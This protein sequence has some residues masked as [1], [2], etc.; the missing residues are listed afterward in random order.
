VVVNE[1]QR[2]AHLLRR[3][4]FGT[5]A[6]E[7][8]GLTAI[9]Y[10][11]VVD[12]LLEDAPVEPAPVDFGADAKVGDLQRAWLAQMLGTPRPLQEKMTLF[13]HQLL[14]SGAPKVQE[15]DW[16]WQQNQLFRQ[17]AL[18]NYGSL[19]TEVGRDPAM[20]RWLDGGQSRKAHPNEN[21]AR[22][23]MELFSMGIG[24]YSEQDVKEAARAFTGWT[25]DKLTGIA[26]LNPKQ[27]DP[28]PK[29]IF[30]T[31][32]P[33]DDAGVVKL[34]L[35]RTATANYLARKLLGFFYADGPEPGF[36][37]RIADTLRSSDYELKPALRAIFMAPE[38]S[39]DAAYRARVKSPTEYVVGLAKH[40]GYD[41]VPDGLAPAM[42]SMGQSLFA[43][44]NVAGW[45]GGS[46][47]WV[48]TSMLLTRF[49]AARGALGK[50]DLSALAGGPSERLFD[51][52]L[53]GDGSPRLRKVVADWLA[54]HGTSV[55]G[56]RG[57]VHLIVSSPTYQMA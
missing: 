3:A 17:N 13:W 39:S 24:N 49:N 54:G 28:G 14:T 6:G 2:T 46:R 23:L 10:S 38:F 51:H 26:D 8:D 12:Q 53:D 18:G 47:A 35:G 57:A 7:L 44:P 19:L 22:E 41:A 42:S 40:L 27:H 52:F 50:A 31:T 55:A 34:I 16:L 48:S 1:R 5:S 45:P 30:G 20:L 37:D 9:G 25:V 29:T 21:Y 36:V 32:G 4:G 11:G 56:V 33:F 15:H 43:P